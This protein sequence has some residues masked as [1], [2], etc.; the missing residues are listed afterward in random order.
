MFCKPDV[1]D[2]LK[3]DVLK[4]DVLKPDVLKPDV[5]W[6]YPINCQNAILH[7][8][9]INIGME[10]FPIN[11]PKWWEERMTRGKLYI[12]PLFSFVKVSTDQLDNRTISLNKNCELYYKKYKLKEFFCTTDD[13]ENRI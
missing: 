1:S 12:V 11:S 8:L 10:S 13:E 7:R 2:V 5:L 9:K 3:P 4:P 6:V